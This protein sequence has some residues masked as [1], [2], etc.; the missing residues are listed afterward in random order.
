MTYA[1]ISD[2]FKRYQPIQTIVGSETLQVTSVDVA[3]IF[4]NDAESFIDAILAKRYTVPLTVV[5][6]YITQITADIAIFNILLEHL[7]KVPD[8]FQPRYDRAMDMLAMINSGDLLVTSATP[9]SAGDQEAW[10]TTD[11]YHPVFS[12]VLDPMDQTV[13]DDRVDADNTTRVG[14]IGAAGTS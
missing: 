5:P 9:V 2:V 7:P 1:T 10:S 3:S 6:A 8:F 12:P 11:G 13:D 4:L 14:D